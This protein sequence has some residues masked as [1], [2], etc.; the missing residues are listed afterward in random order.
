MGTTKTEPDRLTEDDM[1][2]LARDWVEG[3]VF[4]NRD[5]KE[6]NMIRSVFMLI[7]LGGFGDVDTSKIG[8]IYEYLSEAGERSVNGYP[9]FMSVRFVHKEDMKPL[10]EMC[11][12]IDTAIQEATQ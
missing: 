11:Q 9:M 6:D 12:K 7:G 3:R 4:T 10:F 2:T 5:I 8:M 1:K